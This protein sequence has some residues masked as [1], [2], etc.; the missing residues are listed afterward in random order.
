MKKLPLVLSATVTVRKLTATA[1]VKRTNKPGKCNVVTHAGV[2]YGK[3]TPDAKYLGEVALGGKWTQEQI[4]AEFARNPQRWGQK[5][6]PATLTD[7]EITLAGHP[8]A[9]LADHPGELTAEQSLALFASS[10]ARFTQG[11]GYDLARQLKLVA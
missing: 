1:V 5:A 6:V 7:V 9:R 11:T 3:G 4:L 2:W 10:P 8:V